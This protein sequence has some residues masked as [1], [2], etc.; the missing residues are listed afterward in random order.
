MN[1]Q[2][3][4]GTFKGYNGTAV[5][6]L[7]EASGGTKF[8]LYKVL[9]ESTEFWK[10]M[11]RS[12][13]QSYM[14]GGDATLSSNIDLTKMPDTAPDGVLDAE[15][16]V[17]VDNGAGLPRLYDSQAF[18]SIK[19]T[20]IAVYTGD[21][22]TP[23]SGA[24]SGSTVVVTSTNKTMSETISD[25]TTWVTSNWIWVAVGVFALLEVFGVT[26]FL[27]LNKKKKAARRRR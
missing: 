25:L 26:H 8:L 3:N 18:Y 17:S 19:G 13:M 15:G 6:Y 14:A 1:V 20:G 21:I 23:L 10:F 9:E 22:G 7:G 11:P 24:K 2:Y 27:G 5:I 16:N 4:V 12:A